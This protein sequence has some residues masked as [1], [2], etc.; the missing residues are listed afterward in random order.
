M[1]VVRRLRHHHRHGAANRKRVKFAEKFCR[2]RA[3]ITFTWSS[4]PER[5]PFNVSTLINDSRGFDQWGGF[6]ITNS[7]HVSGSVCEAAFC[8]KPYLEVHMRTH[9]G[10]KPCKSNN[11]K[12]LP[13]LLKFIILQSDV[14]FAWSALARNHRW[15][16]TNECTQ[17]RIKKPSSNFRAFVGSFGNLK[18]PFLVSTHP[19]RAYLKSSRDESKLAFNAHNFIAISRP[20][21][22]GRSNV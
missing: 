13:L 22:F 12:S 7:F 5:N 19:I 15:T 21:A 10:E 9:T 16:P 1:S 14:T 17:V 11:R 2:R 20:Q 3:A 4:T 18:I 6:I 8:R